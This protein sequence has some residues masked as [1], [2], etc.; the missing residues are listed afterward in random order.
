MGPTARKFKAPPM[1][2]DDGTLLSAPQVAERCSVSKSTA[3]RWMADAGF[4]V[5]RIGGVVRVR[6]GD[7]DRWI[8]A[9]VR[10]PA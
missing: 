2:G 5:C 6:A 10:T 3:Q 4:P 7:L 9:H 1:P 8:A